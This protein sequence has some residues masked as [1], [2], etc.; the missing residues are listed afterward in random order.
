[1]S[2][3]RLVCTIETSAVDS[4]KRCD[5]KPI[6]FEKAFRVN[7]MGSLFLNHRFQNVPIKIKTNMPK[8]KTINTRLPLSN[9]I[10]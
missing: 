1:M 10:I 7:S 5:E 4:K 8:A 3:F 6:S 9:P 2:D